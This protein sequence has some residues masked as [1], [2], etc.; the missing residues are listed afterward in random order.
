MRAGQRLGGPEVG[1]GPCTKPPLLP[2]GW[3]KGGGGRCELSVQPLPGSSYCKRPPESS[4]YVFFR[5]TAA[6]GNVFP[7]NGAN[8]D[9][10]WVTQ[11]ALEL[12]SEEPAPSWQPEEAWGAG[13]GPASTASQAGAPAVRGCSWAWW[14]VAAW[15][16]LVAGCKG[17]GSRVRRVPWAVGRNLAA[18]ALP[19]YLE[20]LVFLCVKEGGESELLAS[21]MER[22]LL[23]RG[24]RWGQDSTSE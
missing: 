12:A 4:G 3:R 23:L 22:L 5:L 17:L 14:P 9:S 19:A 18:L 6:L 10:K 24:C 7:G 8:A 15:P 11:S 2:S 20:L 21:S 16:G 1:G 13:P